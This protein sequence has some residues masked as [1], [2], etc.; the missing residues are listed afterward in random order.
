MART[1]VF[2]LTAEGV[3][4][5][6]RDLKSMADN[7]GTSLDS[8]KAKFPGLSSVIDDANRKLDAHRQKQGESAAGAGLL[9]G[10]LDKVN[11][12]MSALIGRYATWTAAIVTANRL[13]HTAAE[14]S[15]EL[16]TALARQ[17]EQWN[18]L[19][20]ASEP[21]FTRLAA[22]AA[23]ALEWLNK[24]HDKQVAI[25]TGS[26][27]SR[28]TVPSW[29]HGVV[30]WE[31]VARM[32]KPRTGGIPFMSA[33]NIADSIDVTPALK[34]DLD[35]P[36]KMLADQRRAI[37][38][39]AE[40]IY[41]LSQARQKMYDEWGAAEA[42]R[43][44]AFLASLDAEVKRLSQ[45]GI[46][47][48]KQRAENEEFLAKAKRDGIEREIEDHYRLEQDAR[49]QR[50][51]DEAE[52]NDW[53]VTQG[54]GALLRIAQGGKGAW[55]GMLDEMMSG[56][57]QALIAMARQ[58]QL[59]GKDGMFGG[60]ALGSKPGQIGWIGGGLSAAA[61]LAG[62]LS[63]PNGNTRI[64]SGLGG[65]ASGA[66]YGSAFGPIGTAVG[67]VAGGLLGLLGGG[68]KPSNYRATATFGSGMA[69]FGL[70]GDKPNENTLGLA[71]QAAAAIMQEV[72]SLK[73]F[74]VEF[75]QQLANI[76]IGQRD[77]STY[78]LAGG[79]R[80]GV[81]SV[82]NA[83]DLAQD[84]LTALLKGATSSD[85]TIAAVLK[86]GAPD[87]IKALQF[88]QGITDALAEITNPLE[89]ALDLWQKTA[90][91]NVLM[92]QQSG[93]SLDKIAQYNAALKSQIL[94][95]YYGPTQS[96]LTGFIQNLQFG[97]GSTASP[98][99]QYTASFGAYDAARQ[100]A[101]AN[102]TPES[103]SAFLGQANT[104]LP[105]ARS[106]WA[107]SQPYGA[108]E[109]GALNTAQ[110]LQDMITSMMSG[111]DKTVMAITGTA[112]AQ[113][114]ATEAQTDEVR[115]MRAELSD[116]RAQIAALLARVVA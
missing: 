87:L 70:S 25:A 30:N 99:Q 34:S 94:E 36:E 93:Y 9:G 102:A 63:D 106:Y 26:D 67:A 53:V 62:A 21:F 35:S 45:A 50:K 40:G 39:E 75:Q 22:G 55:R 7:S 51:R 111:G 84:T 3:K 58:G 69:G 77:E 17:E 71:Q 108:L 13:M 66:L 19:A 68:D 10:S 109:Q 101:L 46:E 47:V 42:K 65:A 6:E 5:L 43:H 20:V 44:A 29:L 89:H 103:V 105:I 60:G 4:E 100:A 104:F 76:W 2:R 27:I 49:D 88:A 1:Y 52:F 96:S 24:L 18:R 33:S 28:T 56:W 91:A 85:P 98:E 92:A 110:Q 72:Q 80:I 54:V 116:L 112:A 83:G 78:Q 73:A 113:L 86:S 57:A 79:S 90:E 8:L 14:H 16:K 115:G 11:L 107:S 82:G 114:E 15:D 61:L 12:S 64:S 41:R 95:Q 74:G 81:G 48:D 38:E 31:E 59:F 37:E 97:P 23:D 32:Q